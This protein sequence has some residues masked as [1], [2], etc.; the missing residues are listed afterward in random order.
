MRSQARSPQRPSRISPPTRRCMLDL[1]RR[2]RELEEAGDVRLEL[3][4]R[5]SES[6]RRDGESVPDHATLCD[7]LFAALSN[8]ECAQLMAHGV[9]EFSLD[10]GTTRW[11]LCVRCSA[12]TMRLVGF[13]ASAQS[14]VARQQRQ[15]TQNTPAVI[16]P[17]PPFPGALH[18]AIPPTQRPRWVRSDDLPTVELPRASD[19]P[20]QHEPSMSRGSGS[21]ADLARTIEPGTLC[22]ISGRANAELFAASLR[23]GPLALIV[24]DG[25]ERV[26]GRWSVV[27]P[28]G[29]VVLCVGAPWALVAWMLRRLEEGTSVVVEHPAAS[30]LRVREALLG[31]DPSARVER[32]IDEH[33]HHWIRKIGGAWQKLS[34]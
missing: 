34:F 26:A 25:T 23:G 29:R 15:P 4:A 16:P 21:L 18:D 20:R 27:S 3:V 19:E 33:P 31:F 22:V 5:R 6:T 17:P 7:E 11:N 24:E 2:L 10:V 1:R 32:W 13:R 8:R 14:D 9:L 12:S 30:A 28:G